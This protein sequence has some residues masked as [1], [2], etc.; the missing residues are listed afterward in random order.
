MKKEISLM[1]PQTKW[2]AAALGVAGTLA[3]GTSAQAQLVLSD[4]PAGFTLNAYYASWGTATINNTGP[5]FSITSSGYGSGYYALPSAVNGTGYSDIQM[6]ID[7]AGPGGLP[8]SSAIA[9]LTDAAGSQLQYALQY[10]VQAGLGQTFTLPLSTV[11]ATHLAGGETSFNFANITDFNIE[12]DPGGYSGPYTITYH[13][14]QLI[15]VPEPGT[16]A[17]FGLGGLGLLV[18]RRR[19]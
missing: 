11:N 4:F 16:V 9:D 17:L 13:N 10:G 18:Y 6:T 8:I 19:K 1:K 2:L 14:L 5:G 7:V 3:I 15:N 12:D